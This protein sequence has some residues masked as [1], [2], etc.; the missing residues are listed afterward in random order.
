MPVIPWS[1]MLSVGVSQIDA[2][3]RVL[4]DLLN[5][6][7]D[8]VQ[9]GVASWDQSAVLAELVRYTNTHFRDEEAL[10]LQNGY[11][12]LASHEQ[13]HHDLVKAVTDMVAR[14]AH[15]EQPKAEELVVFLRDWLTAHI[16]GSDRLLGQALNARGVR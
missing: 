14:H 8:V 9:G 16:M 13:Q 3:H 4:V 2:Q 6:L 15:G 7:G 12:D 5:Q 11:A 10:M 1:N